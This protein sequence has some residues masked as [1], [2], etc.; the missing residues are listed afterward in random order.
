MAHA[1]GLTAYCIACKGVVRFLV[2]VHHERACSMYDK[3]RFAFHSRVDQSAIHHSPQNTYIIKNPKTKSLVPLRSAND[4]EAGGRGVLG[5]TKHLIVNSFS[6]F[7][8]RGLVDI[9]GDR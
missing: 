2:L 3:I 7:P 9:V 8:H 5:R 6:S 4:G 1:S